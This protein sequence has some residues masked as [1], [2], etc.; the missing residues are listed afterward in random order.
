MRPTSAFAAAYTGVSYQ[1]TVATAYD[2]II[3][4]SVAAAAGFAVHGRPRTT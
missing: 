2:K 3:G 4:N 1:Q